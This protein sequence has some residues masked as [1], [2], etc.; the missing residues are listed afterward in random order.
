[1]LTPADRLIHDELKARLAGDPRVRFEPAV[2]SSEVAGILASYDVLCC[3]SECAEGGPTVAIEAHS[4][5]TP[6]IG[7]RIGGLAELVSV[8]VN[9]RLSE[10]G[11]VAALAEVLEEVATSPEQ[12]IDRWRDNLPPARTMDDVTS[13][14]LKLY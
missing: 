6:V 2:K 4:V 3:P 12:T 11:D 8:R 1:V 10:P 9:G 13:D 14:Y 7:S 5:G